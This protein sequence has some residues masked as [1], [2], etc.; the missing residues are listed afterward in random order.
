M[1]D[2]LTGRPRHKYIMRINEDFLDSESVDG[3]VRNDEVGI[4]K[5]TD[6]YG[7]LLEAY[8]YAEYEIEKPDAFI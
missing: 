7:W 8:V 2:R 3:I 4:E 6:S 5:I 1:R